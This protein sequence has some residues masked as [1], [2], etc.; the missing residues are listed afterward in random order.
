M[1][2]LIVLLA[3]VLLVGCSDEIAPGRS[4]FAPPVV[5]GLTIA[6]VGMAPISGEQGY[7]GTLESRDRGSVIARTAGRVEKVL[8]VEGASVKAGELLLVLGDN[9]SADQ[10]KGAEAALHEAESSAAAALERKILAYK[11]L[12]RYEQLRSSEAVTPQEFD[13]IASEAAVA[14]KLATA[15]GATVKRM[16]AERDAALTTKGFSQVKATYAGKIAKLQV[17]QG[18]TVLPGTPL[19]EIDRGGNWQVRTALPEALAGTIP[20]GSRL[21]VEIPS[22]GERFMGRVVE[23]S[24]AADSLSRSFEVKIELPEG[25]DLIAGLYARVS[26]PTSACPAVVLPVTALVQRG[27]LSGVFVVEE[28][29]LHYRLVKVG[30]QQDGLVEILSGLKPGEQVVVDGVQKARHGARVEG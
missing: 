16:A 29:I 27:Q 28:G 22:R 18:S 23:V 12:A 1:R 10:L 15:A 11:E 8:V 19:L 20:L 7:P 5:K 9:Q 17:K 4:E 24:P 13:R 25:A 14:D 26:P 21:Q 30:Q 3:T 2:W 6:V